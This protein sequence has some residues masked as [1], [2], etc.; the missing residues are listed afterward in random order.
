MSGQSSDADHAHRRSFSTT[1]ASPSVVVD[2]A[3]DYSLPPPPP[4]LLKP[5]PMI[6]FFATQKP[7]PSYCFSH[8]ASGH[9]KR[10]RQTKTI[11]D[12]Y[13]KS[14]QVGE[15]ALFLR[16]DAIGVADGVGG[17]SENT[18]GSSPALYSR[19]LMHH[20]FLEMERF[21]NLEDPHFCRHAEANP[22]EVLQATYDHSM[23]EAH[24]ENLI[25]SSTACLA[26]LRADEVRV[27]NLGDCGISIIRNNSYIFRSE[28]QQHSF[29]YPFQLG[30]RSRDRPKH[31]QSFN[32]KVQKGDIIIMGS[33]GLFDN[34]FDSE[35][36]ATVRK[37]VSSYIIPGNEHRPARVMEFDPQ[38][39]SDV[40]A[41]QAL[42]ASE[43]KRH[44]DS[45]FQRRAMNS[46]FYFQGGK[47]DDISV[48]VAVVQDSEDSPDRRL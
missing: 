8:G 41:K 42:D 3:F 18:P 9:A 25:G 43:D 47:A 24:R 28:E 2:Q 48:V 13:Y 19:K 20:A 12:N 14:R 45:P 39:L 27:A 32:V 35:I 36:L 10:G 38:G 23:R 7:K 4:T 44:I 46:G 15:D 26:I 37:H 31:A 34:V 1:T 16:H 29:N 22:V 6:D 30:T 33:D 40:L 5:L 17:W 11:Q 21:D